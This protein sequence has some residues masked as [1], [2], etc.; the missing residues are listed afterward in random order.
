[1]NGKQHS[2]KI[3]TN[4]GDDVEGPSLRPPSRKESSGNNDNNTS[5]QS[6]RE[7]HNEKQGSPAAF[8][9]KGMEDHGEG[10][11]SLSRPPLT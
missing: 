4:K 1:M 10:A 11:P 3:G 7:H 9:E 6:D 5:R 8:A 2:R